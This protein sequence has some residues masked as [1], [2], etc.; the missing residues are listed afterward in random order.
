MTLGAISDAH[1]GPQASFDGKLRKL[2]GQAAELSSAFVARMRDEVRPDLLVNLGDAIE[3]ESPT[4]DLERYA[5]YLAILGRAGCEI[6]HVAGNHDRVHLSPETLRRAWGMSPE[7]PL[8]RSFDRGAIHLVV[9]YS[10]EQKDLDVTLGSEQLDWLAADLAA[11]ARDTV[12]LV[13][14]SPADQDLR[15]NR[16]FE[17]DPHL[18]LI[19]DRQRLREL[20]RAHGRTRLVLNGHLHWNHLAV[21]DSIPYVTLQSLVEN[22]DEDAPGRAAAAHALVRIE[23]GGLS[24]DIAGAHPARYQLAR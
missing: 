8:Y 14:H 11:S 7:G 22:V 15:G 18:C 3:D 6:V 23:E 21:V 20:L 19:A 24:V 10:H 12:V 2:S 1:F 13:H 4:A 5:H 9:L 17:R 16:W